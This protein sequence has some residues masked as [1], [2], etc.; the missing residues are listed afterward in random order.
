MKAFYCRFV[1]TESGARSLGKRNYAF[2]ELYRP[3]E[4]SR[5]PGAYVRAKYGERR[6]NFSESI[7][8]SIGNANNGVGQLSAGYLY[9][10]LIPEFTFQQ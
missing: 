3:V 7:G 1:K 5:I 4:Q 8:S 2:F 10:H 9:F 6:A